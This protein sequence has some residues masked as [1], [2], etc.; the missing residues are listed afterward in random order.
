MTFPNNAFS[1]TGEELFKSRTC[2]GSYRALSTTVILASENLRFRRP[3]IITT[4]SIASGVSFPP[5]AARMPFSR[6]TV[7]GVSSRGILKAAE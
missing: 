6:R 5:R 4:D 2:S 1:S 3:G 7:I